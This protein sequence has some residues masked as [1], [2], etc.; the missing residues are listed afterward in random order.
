MADQTSLPSSPTMNPPTSP[1]SSFLNSPRFFSGLLTKK[2]QFSDKDTTNYNYAVMSPTS[3]L[4]SKKN[5]SFVNPFGHD[6]KML[7][8]SPNPTAQRGTNKAIGLALIDSI[9]QENVDEGKSGKISKPVNRAAL[10]GSKLKVQIPDT[11]PTTSSVEFGIKTRNPQI[12]SPC[13]STPVKDFA[14]QLSLKE[15]ELSEDYTCV[16]S[17]GP[18]PKTTH[19]FDDCVVESCLGD[20]SENNYPECKKMDCGVFE[21]DYSSS[22]SSPSQDFLSFCHTCKDSLGQGKDIYIYKGEK[23]FCSH[24]C[25]CQEM[26]FEGL[27]NPDLDG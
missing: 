6:N 17:H 22:S 18:N 4:D 8:K 27:K 13:S 21:T 11:N 12:S 7:S 24:E 5:L 20:H 14:R 15:M 26:F 1:I 25:R 19:I 16:I 23:A 9:D 2:T 10:F 3:I